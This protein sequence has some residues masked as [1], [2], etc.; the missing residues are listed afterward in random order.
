MHSTTEAASNKAAS[1]LSLSSASSLLSYCSIPS[2]HPQGCLPPQTVR[3]HC[4]IHD[5]T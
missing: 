5:S 2:E 4:V 1:S 3:Q